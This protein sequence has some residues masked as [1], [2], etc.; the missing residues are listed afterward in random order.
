M[1]IVRVISFDLFVLSVNIFRTFPHSDF[2]RQQLF[3]RILC[4]RPCFGA[5]IK[6]VLTKMFTGAALVHLKQGS[7]I[8]VRWI[9]HDQAN[10]Y[11]GP[12][13]YAW[14]K[15]LI[16]RSTANS[17]S[18]WRPRQRQY[19]VS[20]E[21]QQIRSCTKRFRQLLN[22]CSISAYLLVGPKLRH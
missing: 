17:V 7:V 21:G 22:F 15:L 6:D 18:T 9:V 14:G 2:T 4:F 1:Y 10:V 11:S 8:A 16:S 12:E 19:R 20:W 13:S 3:L 5:A